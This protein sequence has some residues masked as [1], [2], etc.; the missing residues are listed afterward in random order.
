MAAANHVGI[1]YPLLHDAYVSASGTNCVLYGVRCVYGT[2]PA[3]TSNA[4]QHYNVAMGVHASVTRCVSWMMSVAYVSENGT[5]C[6]GRASFHVSVLFGVGWGIIMQRGL[7]MHGEQ[8][9]GDSSDGS[10]IN[11]DNNGGC[12]WDCSS[13]TG[14][15]WCGGGGG[16]AHWLSRPLGLRNDGKQATKKKHWQMALRVCW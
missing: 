8:S 1:Q 10:S 15:W 5:S 12:S 4:G 13:F 3:T 2:W 11:Y 14:S 7:I 9:V 16:E 6:E